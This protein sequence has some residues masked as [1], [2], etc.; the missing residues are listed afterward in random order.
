MKSGSQNNNQ[1]RHRK[2]Q[3]L[4]EP[5]Y[6]ASYR[7][8][9]HDLK[10]LNDLSPKKPVIP[11][12]TILPLKRPRPERPVETIEETQAL[13]MLVSLIEKTEVKIP[14][15]QSPRIE[16][17]TVKSPKAQTPKSVNVQ[18]TGAYQQAQ[19][20][21]L[22]MFWSQYMMMMQWQNY[23]ANL[24]YYGGPVKKFQTEI[25]QNVYTDV[26]AGNL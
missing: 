2:T 6:Q 8:V 16:K 21:K 11:T 22:G 10:L 9:M 4:I 19:M 15:A 24:N 5:L 3:R 12:E 1:P 14:K 20:M 17:T 7:E 13:E 25:K 18:P 23:Y 26:S